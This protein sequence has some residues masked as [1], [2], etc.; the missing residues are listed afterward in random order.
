MDIKYVAGLF[1]GEGSCWVYKHKTKDCQRGWYFCPRAQIS[2]TNSQIMEKLKEQLGGRI[3]ND[4]PLSYPK[5]WKPAYSWGINAYDDIIPFLNSILPYLIIKK[6]VAKLLIEF[7][8]IRKTLKR[9]YVFKNGR[10]AKGNQLKY[11]KRMFEI[12]DAIRKINHRRTKDEI[13]K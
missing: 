13:E 10:F 11:P 3:H 6:Q 5:H 12:Y 9:T 4:S 7:C 2:N 8:E 1:D